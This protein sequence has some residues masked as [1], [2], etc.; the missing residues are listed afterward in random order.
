MQD[1]I[2]R[3]KEV[4]IVDRRGVVLK[5]S[6][7][8]DFYIDLKKAF[9]FPDAL[10]L[11]AVRM[12]ERIPDEVNCVAIEGYGG[13]PLGS[14]VSLI[15]DKKLILVRG[16]AKGHGTGALID[17]YYPNRKD[18]VIVLDDVLTSGNSLRKI[19]HVVKNTGAK[20]Y[21]NLVVVNRSPQMRKPGVFND[22]DYLIDAEDLF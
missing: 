1:L 15:G 17:G 6:G 4:D 10:Q 11:M 5:H 14:A 19:R 22:V 13:M 12:L 21:G 9:G 2:D 8:S 20:I 16:E 3:L 18:S 7:K